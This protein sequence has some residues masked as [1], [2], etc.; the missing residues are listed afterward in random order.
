MTLIPAIAD[1]IES[2]FSGE[3]YEVN[4]LELMDGGY[5][6]SISKGGL[7]KAVLGMKTALK[8]DIQPREDAIFIQAGVGIFGQQAVPTVISMFIFWPVLIPQIWGMVH[9]AKLDD[10]VIAIASDYIIRKSHGSAEPA[11]SGTFCTSCGKPQ[12]TAVNFCGHCGVK[13]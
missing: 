4:S 5:D 11:S 12:P 8:V 13:L 1:E 6:I 3:G 2:V 10:R 7:F 9:Q